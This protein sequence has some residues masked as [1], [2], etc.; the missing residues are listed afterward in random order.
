MINE[1]MYFIEAETGFGLDTYL[2]KNSH[3]VS[4]EWYPNWIKN[5]NYSFENELKTKLVC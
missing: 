5:L 2:F 4:H 1:L 3:S